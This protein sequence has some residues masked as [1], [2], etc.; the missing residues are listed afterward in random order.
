ML[1]L[2][3]C[4]QAV[5]DDEPSVP[6]SPTPSHVS[7]A[8]SAAGGAAVWELQPDKPLSVS[9]ISFTALV[10][11]L[12]CN[13][14]VTGAVLAPNV[15]IRPAEVVVT[16]QVEPGNPHGGNCQGNNWVPYEV[17]LSEPI[18]HRSLIDGECLPGQEAE[19]TSF[20]R[21]DGR[22]WSP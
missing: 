12:A 20:C 3:A 22:R 21:P 19:R 6:S 17:E 9:S 1:S 8:P 4:E 13:S 15:Q 5:P 14:G 18:G 16:F 7:Q 10:S 11:R 2:M